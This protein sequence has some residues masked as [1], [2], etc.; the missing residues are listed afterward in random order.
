MQLPTADQHGTDFR[1]LTALA[2][3]PVRL[4]IDGEELAEMEWL[5]E[6]RG[7]E[8]A[9]VRPAPDGSTVLVLPEM[10]LGFGPGG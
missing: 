6:Q 2:G 8:R 7:H 3:E 9:F 1:H 4:G 5:V 10:W